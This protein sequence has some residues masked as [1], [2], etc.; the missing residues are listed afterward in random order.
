MEEIDRL[1]SRCLIAIEEAV[2]KFGMHKFAERSAAEV[3]DLDALETELR[4]FAADDAIAVLQGIIEGD[5]ERGP[6]VVSGLV[7]GLQ[8][9]DALWE[10]PHDEFVQKYY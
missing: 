2:Q 1:T 5:P 4:A 9:W 6:A 10:P 7:Y 3:M 8:D